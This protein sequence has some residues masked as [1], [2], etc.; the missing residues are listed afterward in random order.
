MK[1]I[2]VV[3]DSK[4]QQNLISGVLKIMGVEVIVA[5][6]GEAAL[7]WL[8]INGQPDA[9]LMDIVMPNLNGFDVCR[10]IR[11]EL[12]LKTVPIIFCSQKNQDFDKF[13]ALRQGGNAYLTKPYSPGDLISA[14]KEYL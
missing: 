14:V 8:T 3:D 9:I 2:L 1:K 4:A 12:R 5:D 6:N 7:N 11:Q 13:W 10:R